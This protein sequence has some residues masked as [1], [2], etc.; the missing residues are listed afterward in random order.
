[1]SAWSDE[2]L[3]DLE[4]EVHSRFWRGLPDIARDLVLGM[5]EDADGG[6][7]SHEAALAHRLKLMEERTFITAEHGEVFER[8]FSLCEH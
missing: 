2:S 8:P 6:P 3:V 4:L 5:L 7:M 1:M